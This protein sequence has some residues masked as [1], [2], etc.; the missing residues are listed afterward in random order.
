MILIKTHYTITSMRDITTQTASLLAS[1]EP[2]WGIIFAILILG[3]ISS[4]RTRLDGAIII[5]AALLPGILR[6]LRLGVILSAVC[7]VP[8][9]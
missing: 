2:V 9:S 1:L 6:L 8:S 7:G 4:P 5:T 3:A